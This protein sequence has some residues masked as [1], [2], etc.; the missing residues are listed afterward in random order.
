MHIIFEEVTQWLVPIIKLL[1]YF[2]FKVFYL[3]IKAKSKFQKNEIAEKLKMKGI[4]PLPLEFLSNIPKK[5]YS[6]IAE[7]AAISEQSYM[8]CDR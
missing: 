3:H 2:N 8:F 5:F 6:L 7:D 1:K 4:T